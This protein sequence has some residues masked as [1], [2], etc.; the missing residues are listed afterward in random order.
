MGNVAEFEKY[1]YK[2]EPGSVF[3]NQKKMRRY[4]K[5]LE[6]IVVFYNL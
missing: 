1:K 2:K 4:V 5:G 3:P 6:D